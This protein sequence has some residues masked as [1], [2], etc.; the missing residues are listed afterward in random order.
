[1]GEEE[2]LSNAGSLSWNAQQQV[3]KSPVALSILSSLL[4]DRNSYSNRSS[5]ECFFPRSG[6]DTLGHT[7]S[8]VYYRS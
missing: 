7:T 3:S 5:P 6:Y 1:M 4:V 2:Q 8:T